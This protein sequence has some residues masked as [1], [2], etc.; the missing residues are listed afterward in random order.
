MPFSCRSRKSA[1]FLPWIVL[2]ATL[3]G[4]VAVSAPAAP[5]AMPEFERA[6]ARIMLKV[7]REDLERFYYDTGFHGV[8]MDEAFAAASDKIDKAGSISQLFAALARPMLQLKDS[9]TRFLPPGRSVK[10][11]FGW[12]MQNF[13]EECYV[14]AV[15]PKS[16]AAAKGLKVGDLILAIDGNRPSREGLRGINYVYRAI[17]P[18]PSFSLNVKSPGGEPRTITIEAR[19]EQLKKVLDLTNPSAVET[20]LHDLDEEAHRGRH[21]IH[22][23]GPQLVIWRMPAFDLTGAEVD[24]AMRLVRDH[25][26]AILDLRGNP[27]GAIET[28]ERMV[29]V[30]VGEGVKVGDVKTREEMKPVVSKKAGAVYEGKIVVLVDSDSGSSAELLSRVIQ[31]AG[32]GPV[33]GDRTAGAVMMSRTYSHL[34]GDSGGAVFANQVTVADIIMTDGKSLEKGGVTPDTVMLPKAEDLAAGRDP[35][36]AHAASLL[37]ATISPEQAGALFPV[38]WEK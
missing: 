29:G 1:L 24:N 6:R 35:V 14:T 10:V 5:K 13:G 32:R 19:L 27:G 26:G 28:L 9:H 3:A 18:R 16:D 23:F 30:F 20:Y 37:G 7:I 12:Q 36:L 4:D 31:L 2:L 38:E 22:Q 25:Q 33:I 15:Q 21:K 11:H 17:A 8:N 34:L